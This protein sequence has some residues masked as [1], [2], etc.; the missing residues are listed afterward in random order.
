MKFIKSKRGVKVSDD[1]DEYDFED[2]EM[3]NEGE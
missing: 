3:V 1:P 2:G